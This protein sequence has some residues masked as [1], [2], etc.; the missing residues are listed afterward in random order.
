LVAPFVAACAE[1]A[2][3]IAELHVVAG[4]TGHGTDGHEYQFDLPD[5]VAPGPTRVSLANE[6]AEAH[7]AQLFRLG[8]GQTVEDLTAALADGGP[9][10]ALEVGEYVGGT[11]LVAPGETSDAE[12]VVELEP[13]NYVFLC[14]VEAPDGQPHVAHGMLHPFTVDGSAESPPAPDA[15]VSVQL[16]D[17]GFELPDTIDGDALLEITNAAAAEPHEMEVARLDD[18]ATIDDVA[19]ALQD[20]TDV[21]ATPVGGLQGILPGASQ[22]LQL[23]LE[24]GR[25]VVVCEVPSPDGTPHHV[26]GMIQEVAVT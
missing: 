7:H 3:A 14:L 5:E 11:A 9:P 15:D 25:Y 23:D 1:E 17:Y 21:P 20:G 24:P 12:A 16:V 19:S 4:G 6:G 18:G 2:A 26:K 10:A 8:D 22:L 13:G